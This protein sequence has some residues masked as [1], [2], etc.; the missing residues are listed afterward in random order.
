MASNATF[1]FA[2]EAPIYNIET[3][4]FFFSSNDGGPLGNSDM[5]R[6]NQVGKIS[7]KQITSALQSVAGKTDGSA[8]PAAVN[9]PVTMVCLSIAC[10]RERAM[11]SYRYFFY[12][13]LVT[14]VHDLR[15]H[16]LMSSST[17]QT[18]SK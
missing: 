4:E 1:A 14:R 15:S 6:N 10:R 13:F 5:N 2:H 9:V 18:P 8:A 3:D 17:S 7:M 12:N 11:E 16:S